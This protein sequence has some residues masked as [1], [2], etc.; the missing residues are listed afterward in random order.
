MALHIAVVCQHLPVFCPPPQV[1]LKATIGI[2]KYVGVT[3]IVRPHPTITGRI[4]DQR[5][6]KVTDDIKVKVETSD[7]FEIC[8]AE[9]HVLCTVKARPSTGSAYNQDLIFVRW[10][11]SPEDDRGCP[12][13]MRPLVWEKAPGSPAG[14]FDMIGVM[15]VVERICVVPDWKAG[16]GNFLV[17]ELIGQPA[18]DSLPIV[19]GN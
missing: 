19:A 15:A 12:L 9:V 5:R 11:C 6:P 13:T 8:F 16:A 1:E 3:D 18:E 10:Y 2:P 14:R 7:G 17:N 4:W